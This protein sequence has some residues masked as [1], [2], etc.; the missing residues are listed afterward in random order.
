MR[1][2]RLTPDHLMRKPISPAAPT[3]VDFRTVEDGQSSYRMLRDARSLARREERRREVADPGQQSLD[4]C[5]EWMT[6]RDLARK[7]LSEESKDTE[8]L[9]WL[10]EAETR[11]D[12]HAGLARSMG[13]IADLVRD[14]GTALHPLPESDED[15]QFAAIAGLNGVGREGSLIQPLRLVSL[16]P[17]GSYG[18]LTLWDVESDRAADKVEQAVIEAGQEAMRA[19]HAEVLAA[20]SAVRECDEVL[21]SFAGAKAPPF[22]Q[23]ID[24]LDDTE[25][26]IRRLARLDAQPP[27]A[28]LPARNDD[29]PAPHPAP[30]AAMS[31]QIGSREQAFDELLRIAAY[32]R[33][34]EPHSPISYSI[35]TLVRRGRMDFPSLLEEL[36]PDESTRQAVMTTAGIRDAPKREQGGS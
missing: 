20:I 7:I 9:V 8:V 34:A 3:G 30:S 18:H 32:F 10:A 6:V 12:G 16:V 13:L 1:H 23:I 26:T 19:H 25:R 2:L 31:G 14:Y 33:K 27:L 36:I 11:I 22:T 15:D 24:V 21:S 28:A 29:T 5:P 17:K 35:E 4:L